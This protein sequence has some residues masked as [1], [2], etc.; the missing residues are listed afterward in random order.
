[1][2][3]NIKY[4]SSQPVILRIH[5]YGCRHGKREWKK[6]NNEKVLHNYNDSSCQQV[7]LFKPHQ[8]M[9]T[10]VLSCIQLDILYLHRIATNKNNENKWDSVLSMLT[11]SSQYY[12]SILMNE[13]FFHV[14]EKTYLQ[15]MQTELGPGLRT[16]NSQQH[17][18]FIRNYK[19]HV[20]FPP[21]NPDRWK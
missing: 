7:F 13:C 14:V 10:V 6:Q 16:T 15:I 12:I 17:L 18:S 1:M 8:N 9:Y 21:R 11:I 5:I 20:N 2:L 19:N 3:P 4:D